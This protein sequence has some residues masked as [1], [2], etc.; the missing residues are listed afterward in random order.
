M[1][2]LGQTFVALKKQSMRSKEVV[3]V[4]DMVRRNAEAWVG[5]TVCRRGYWC[6][7]EGSLLVLNVL[8]VRYL[9]SFGVI[10]A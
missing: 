6:C 2:A 7:D 4:S 1:R 3:S 8:L 10:D 9:L 5:V